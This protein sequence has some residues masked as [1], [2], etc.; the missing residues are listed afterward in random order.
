MN[1]PLC[2]GSENAVTGLFED[3]FRSFI[4]IGL[5]TLLIRKHI[6]TQDCLAICP[7]NYE[8]KYVV[9]DI[10]TTGFGCLRKHM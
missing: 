6:G 3:Y 7:V 1:L 8:P 9:S 5:G 10:R 2:T 4:K